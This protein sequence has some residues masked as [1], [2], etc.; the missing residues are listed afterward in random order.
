M[1]I[2]IIEDEPLVAKNIEKLVRELHPNALLH[3]PLASVE[4]A[5]KWFD[6]HPEPDLILADIQLAD[7]VSFDIFQE[8]T[9]HCPIIFTTAYDEYAIRAFKLNS[10]DYLLKP[11]DKQELTTSF[12]KFQRWQKTTSTDFFPSQLRDLLNDLKPH[13]Q[14]KYKH[15]FTAHHQ[16]SV[17]AVADVRIA[18]FVRDEVIWLATTDHQRLITDYQSLDEIEELLD[19]VQFVRANRQYIVRKEAIE[20]YRTHYSGKIELVLSVPSKE[21]IVISKDRAA[22]FRVWFE[23]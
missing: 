22:S 19:P 18:Y 7:G 6:E 14:K 2:L 15:R 1:T 4:N 16:R 9:L 8:R 5:L 11:I 13:S 17:V 21:E 20:S 12:D 10:I 3:G 23:E